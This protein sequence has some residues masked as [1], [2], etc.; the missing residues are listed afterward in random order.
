MT[1]MLVAKAEKDTVW[2][3][4]RNPPRS[5]VQL[6]QFILPPFAIP[7]LIANAVGPH[8]FPTHWQR[9]SG[10]LSAAPTWHVAGALGRAAR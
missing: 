7:A 5:L 9:G 1:Q 8:R 3:C 10:G 4:R 6:R 2:G